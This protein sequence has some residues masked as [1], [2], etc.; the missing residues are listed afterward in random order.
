[1]YD[2]PIN[3]LLPVS[4][5]ERINSIDVLRGLAMFGVLI[6]FAVW[7]LGGPPANTLGAADKIIEFVLGILV[8]SKAYT[9]LAFLFGVGFSIQ[10]A[11]ADDRGANIVPVYVRRLIAM[12][13]IGLAHAL[14]LRNGD[15][16]V[17][18]ATMGFVL[19][20]FRNL[21][22]RGLIIAAIVS[23]FVALIAEFAW[24]ASGIP[25]PARPQTEGMS[26]LAANL[27]WVKYWYSTAIT[28]WPNSLPMFFVGLYVGRRRLLENVA[29][30]RTALRV[31]AIGGFIL[32]LVIMALQLWL[33]SIAKP[34]SDNPAWLGMLIVYGRNAHAWPI[35]ASY[36]A[37]VLLLL[38]RRFWQRLLSPLASV[39]RMALTN[40]LMQASVIVP[41]CIIFD[42]Y[43]HVTPSLG[44][45]MAVLLWTVQ[46][47]FSVFWLKHF[48]FG[49]A[50][51]LWRSLT[52]KRAQPMRYTITRVPHVAALQAVD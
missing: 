32:G 10:M 21:S 15:I 20:L 41:V 44:L 33:M 7:N 52:Y 45:L 27:L 24:E 48:R 16:L 19:L 34:G 22:N 11:R 3:A 50:E 43:D 4:P 31:L 17:P 37:T 39:G 49:P 30:H 25:F 1:M 46:V 28:L 13:A 26:H 9:T 40:Y 29:T 38:Q 6:A 14:L 2:K 5:A 36:I 35:A 23:S 12:M 51:W 8:D 18:Y 42:L 47:P